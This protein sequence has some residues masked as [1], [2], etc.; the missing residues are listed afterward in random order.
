MGLSCRDLTYFPD[1]LNSYQCFACFLGLQE[2]PSGP[3]FAP[4]LQI[5]GIDGA[6]CTRQV[7]GSGETL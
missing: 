7:V 2:T 3:L 4:S 6:P 5:D 1:C